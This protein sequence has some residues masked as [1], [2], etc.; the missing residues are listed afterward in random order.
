LFV[1]FGTLLTRS[2]NKKNKMLSRNTIT[3]TNN[4]GQLHD[5]LDRNTQ[6]PEI[7]KC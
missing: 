6:D 1:S 4:G 2:P 5:I 3:E 7:P